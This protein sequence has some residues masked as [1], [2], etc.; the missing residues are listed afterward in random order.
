MVQ[1][2]RI[3]LGTIR[4]PV[5]SLAS[6]SGLRIQRCMSCGVGRRR[7]S[8]PALLWLWHGLTAVAPMRPLAWEPPYAMGAAL[9]KDK[10]Q[11]KKERERRGIELYSIF[12]NNLHGKKI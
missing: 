4:L 9:K 6:L 8:D 2:K 1:W 7:H 10:R 3:R 12:C 11:K 5:R